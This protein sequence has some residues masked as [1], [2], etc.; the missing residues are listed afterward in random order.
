M[1]VKS[2]AQIISGK[3]LIS[4]HV[5][6][7]SASCA[8]FSFQKCLRLQA[9]TCFLQ[10]GTLLKQNALQQQTNL[11]G[12]LPDI[13]D[14]LQS[15]LLQAVDC[16]QTRCAVLLLQN[17]ARHTSAVLTCCISCNALEFDEPT[18]ELKQ[19][20]AKAQLLAESDLTLSIPEKAASGR[21]ATRSKPGDALRLADRNPHKLV[22]IRPN[23]V[24]QHAVVLRC[25]RT[26]QP[27][28]IFFS[29]LAFTVTFLR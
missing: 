27:V 3:C 11:M 6:F 9:K 5:L 10:L 7:T 13:V 12:R 29:T 8:R 24:V 2:P 4:H 22:A 17:H 28:N 25:H 18:A 14:T 26:A 23:Y 16:S 19:R 21:R 15:L 1:L 20:S